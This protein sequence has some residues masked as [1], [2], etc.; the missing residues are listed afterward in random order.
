MLNL[1]FASETTFF[2]DFRDYFF[3]P[4]QLFPP[5]D[6]INISN[7]R[8]KYFNF[9][10]YYEMKRSQEKSTRD[11]EIDFSKM[12]EFDQNKLISHQRQI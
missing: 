8:H 10:S 12:P 11:L 3:F 1:G 9:N 5:V 4:T 6:F 2:T 7:Y